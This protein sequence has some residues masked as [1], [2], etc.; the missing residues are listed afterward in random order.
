MIAAAPRRNANGDGAIL[1]WRNGRSSARRPSSF[2]RSRGSMSRSS[3]IQ[4][5]V[6]VAAIPPHGSK[7][8]G[9][10]INNLLANYAHLRS[11]GS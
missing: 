3:V 11:A 6:S 1:P 10:V 5:A 8:D 4:T 2:A 9:I 7:S